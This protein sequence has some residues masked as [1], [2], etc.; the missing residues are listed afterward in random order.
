MLQNLTNVCLVITHLPA[1]HQSQVNTVAFS[2]KGDLCVSGGQDNHIL[3]WKLN[4]EVDG[5]V[6]KEKV[7][8]EVSNNRTGTKDRFFG[9]GF[10]N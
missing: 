5:E 9:D 3:V 7:V 1:G 2:P 6:L 10:L 8:Q 4:L